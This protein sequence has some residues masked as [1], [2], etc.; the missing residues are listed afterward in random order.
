MS[1]FGFCE[2]KCK[3]NLDNM[4]A[5]SNY[6]AEEKV[7]GTW[8]GKP[9]YKKTLLIDSFP[10]NGAAKHYHGIVNPDKVFV[11]VSNSFIETKNEKN[12]IIPIVSMNGMGLDE[13]I[14]LW[15]DKEVICLYANVDYSAYSG[16]VT[17]KYT[18]TTD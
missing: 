13:K 2:N 11:D 18:K 10:N 16:V 9:L 3:H 8:F 14:S 5:D 15:A 12:V 4:I 7:I 17:L 6:S 1:V